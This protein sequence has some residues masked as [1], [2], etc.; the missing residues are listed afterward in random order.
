MILHFSHIGLTDGLTFM[1][2]FGGWVPATRLWLPLRPPLPSRGYVPGTGQRPGA[3]TGPQ[4]VATSAGARYPLCYGLAC[5]LLSRDGLAR[6]RVARVRGKVP[7]REDQWPS[8]GDGDGELEVRCG[9]AILGVDRPAIAAHAHAC[10]P[11]SGH[12]L[13]GKHHALLQQRP[14]AWLTVVGH[15]RILVHAAPH[16]VPD[17]RAH[18]GETGLLDDAL[19]RAGDVSDAISGLALGNTGMQRLLGGCKQAANI[20]LD[21]PHWKRSCGVSNPAVER[22]ADV[23]GDTVSGLE[24]V[25]AWDAMHDHGVGRGTNGAGKATVALEGG[26][27]AVGADEALSELVA[28]CSADTWSDL[29]L[30]L[31]K[32]GGQDQ[33]GLSHLVDLLRGLLDDHPR[34]LARQVHAGRRVRAGGCVWAGRPAP[35]GRSGERLNERWRAAR[36]M[37]S[38]KRSVATVALTCACTSSAL[39][40]PSKRRSSPASS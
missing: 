38:S 36:Y 11:S 23:D 35:A 4:I 19:D 7:R 29:A 25:C 32:R 8:G 10:T 18:D 21:G 15:L 22:D 33:T 30:H 27:G 40:L 5:C 26:D 34:S 3:W 20:L 12:G 6:T 2:P 16:T 9:R 1:I 14:L 17:Q 39:R 31:V 24:L 13:D 37:P 28:L